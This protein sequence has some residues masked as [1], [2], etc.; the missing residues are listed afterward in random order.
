MDR[1]LKKRL[2]RFRDGK[3]RKLMQVT[4]GYYDNKF[5]DTC[6]FCNCCSELYTGEQ[7]RPSIIHEEDC[8]GFSL[9]ESLFYLK[10]DAAERCKDD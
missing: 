8:I 5:Q 4:K 2:I 1:L 9:L 3:L 7:E 6:M 10:R